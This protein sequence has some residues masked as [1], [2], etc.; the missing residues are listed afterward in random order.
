MPQPFI[1]AKIS[2]EVIYDILNG[3]LEVEG[4]T[5]KRL[6]VPV[7]WCNEGEDNTPSERLS[8]LLASASTGGQTYAFMNGKNMC[9]YF[10][11]DN[12]K[13]PIE[14][15][16]DDEFRKDKSDSCIGCN[17]YEDFNICTHCS[18][19]HNCRLRECCNGTIDCK[20]CKMKVFDRSSI[21]N[22]AVLFSM[23]YS[24]STQSV[25]ICCLLILR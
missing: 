5:F 15:F 17:H 21:Q 11:F 6:Q 12:S 19:A 25:W 18:K 10:G 24:R 20:D 16:D 14:Q 13:H 23:R 22:V 4:N 7:A 9:A 3:I 1:D 8:N 2:E